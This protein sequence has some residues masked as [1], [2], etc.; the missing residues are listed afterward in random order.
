MLLRAID[1][2]KRI[3]VLVPEITRHDLTYSLAPGDVL[4]STAIPVKITG[5]LTLPLLGQLPPAP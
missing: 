4:K 2:K 3:D 5:T 1:P